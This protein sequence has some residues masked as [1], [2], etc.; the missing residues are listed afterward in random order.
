M[1]QRRSKPSRFE[2][3]IE[4]TAMRAITRHLWQYAM[5][6]ALAIG[7]ACRAK[8]NELPEITPITRVTVDNRNYLDHTV[9]V[10]RGSERIRLGNA[11]GNQRTT[12]RI[13]PNIIFGG[14]ALRFIADP[15]G[16]RGAPVSDEITVHPGDNVSLMIPP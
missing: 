9:Y 4:E 13:P 10:L 2:R 8:P 5:V 15:I 3:L 14:T 1:A 7:I 16:A 11:T 12:F 6:A